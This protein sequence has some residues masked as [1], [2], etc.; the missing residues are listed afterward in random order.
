MVQGS[1][2]P[3]ITFL[4]E[5]L[6]PGAWNKKI[7]SVIEGK[8]LKMPIKCVK[9]K[10]SKN[11]KMRFFLMSQGSLNPK[12]R[13]LGQK[14]WPVARGQT[15]RRTDR[16]TRKWKQRA[17]FQEFFL[18]HIIK[19][20]P[21]NCYIDTSDLHAQYQLPSSRIVEFDQFHHSPPLIHYKRENLVHAKKTNLYSINTC[22]SCFPN[23][24][25]C[26]KYI[27]HHK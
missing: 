15:D 11:K 19:D 3:N 25:I 23:S 5:K 16:R 24:S 9:M 14:V 27:C 13:F 21:K 20:R 10:I 17:P 8:N 7:T 4:G 1:L 2:N 18:Q 22:V 26:P 6:W 12:I